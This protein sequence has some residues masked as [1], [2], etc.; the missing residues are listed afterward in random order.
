MLNRSHKE[1]VARALSKLY[2][3][4]PTCFF[5]VGSQSHGKLLQTPESQ[6]PWLVEPDGH[7]EFRGELPQNTVWRH[8][9]LNHS[10]S[11]FPYFPKNS[12]EFTEFDIVNE[13]ESLATYAFS[14]IKAVLEHPDSWNV[15]WVLEP[16]ERVVEF[17][18]EKEQQVPKMLKFFNGKP[19]QRPLGYI[20]TDVQLTLE[21]SCNESDG[22]HAMTS[23]A[24]SIEGSVFTI[25]SIEE[26]VLDS[27]TD[28]SCETLALYLHLKEPKV[29][30]IDHV[31]WQL[32]N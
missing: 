14:I 12:V 29:N 1:T 23:R 25:G 28:I 21:Y 10:L 30:F 31:W 4:I 8:K 7:Q 24:L 3:G 27:H 6:G 20:M 26:E 2:V 22:L 17:T 13:T 5:T 19:L 18:I 32:P 16:A 9:S 15:V 11:L